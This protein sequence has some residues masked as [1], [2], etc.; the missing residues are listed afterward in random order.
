MLQLE[1]AQGWIAQPAATGGGVWVGGWG[2]K[3]AKSPGQTSGRTDKQT[4][5]Q[6]DRQTD[7]PKTIQYPLL[8]AVTRL[9]IKKRIAVC[10]TSTAPLRELTCHMGS[11]SVTCHPAEVTFTPLPQP[12]KAGTRFSD[13]SLTSWLGY[14]PRWYTC[15]KTVTHPGINW[16]QR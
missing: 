14:I 4:N 16:A 13:P 15:P 1:S 3:R 11:H 8:R 12:I 7:T 10:A 6:P 2:D 9:L 5:R